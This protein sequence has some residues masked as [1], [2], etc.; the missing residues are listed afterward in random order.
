MR[1]FILCLALLCSAS[2]VSAQVAPVVQQELAKIGYEIAAEPCGQGARRTV[3][4]VQN[5]FEES[6]IDRR[7]TVRCKGLVLV[8][9]HAA[10][11]NPPHQIL[12]SLSLRGPHAK[13][14]AH[15]SPGATRQ[16]VLAFA[17]K[18]MQASS[19]SLVYLLADEGPDQHTATFKFAGSKLT[20]V[21]WWWSSQ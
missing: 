21:T 3:Q 19:D 12:E 11:Y 10:I 20:S 18:P 5:T 7:E 8:V 16:D 13:L 6:V 14:P 4:A 15:I 2:T 17:G 9:Y 1:F